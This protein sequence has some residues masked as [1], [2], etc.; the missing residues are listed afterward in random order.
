MIAVYTSWGRVL[1]ENLTG[2]KRIAQKE[3]VYS[4][5]QCFPMCICL[6]G[7]RKAILVKLMQWA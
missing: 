3:L 1:T 2:V 6:I 7:K 4:D 5:S